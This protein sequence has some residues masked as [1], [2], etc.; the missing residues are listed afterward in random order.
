MTFDIHGVRYSLEHSRPR[1]RARFGLAISWWHTN[2]ED[3]LFQLRLV[4][5]WPGRE[6]ISVS[7][8]SHAPPP[9]GL[10]GLCEYVVRCETDGGHQDGT[11][12]H[13]NGAIAPLWDSPR[14]GVVAHTDADTP[15]L[16][17]AWFFGWCGLLKASE[18]ALLTSTNSYDY[19]H[20]S[21]KRVPHAA[22]GPGSHT[23]RQFGSLFVLNLEALLGVAYWPFRPAGNFEGDRYEQFLACGLDP[24]KDAIILPR[25]EFLQDG[26]LRNMDMS[27]GVMHSTNAGPD[28]K[29][30]LLSAMG[31]EEL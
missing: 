16:G 23:D 5:R 4:S 8:C 17:P 26:P 11:T 2:Q 13:C 21:L 24:V 12:M 25:V 22:L 18:K 27:L 29:R 15:L 19:D 7:V 6:L 9:H 1:P 3:L 30:R 10:A 14:V 28:R 31:L 20:G